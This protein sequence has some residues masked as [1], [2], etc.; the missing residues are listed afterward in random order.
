M[1]TRGQAPSARGP[2][3]RATSAPVVG[4]RITRWGAL[5]VVMPAAC[6]RGCGRASGVAPGRRPVI[7]RGWSGAPRREGGDKAGAVSRLRGDGEAA[8]EQRGPLA[9]AA[10]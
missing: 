2:V 6:C 8:A 9:H 7:S 4:L 5:I 3:Q 1:A 10:Q